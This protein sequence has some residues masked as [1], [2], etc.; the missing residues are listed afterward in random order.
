M[1]ALLLIT[2]N[3]IMAE[4][5]K[6]AETKKKAKAAAEAR[7]QINEKAALSAK[8]A[9]VVTP[10]GPQHFRVVNGEVYDTQKSELWDTRTYQLISR[11]NNLCIVKPITYQKT[12]SEHYRPAG[13]GLTGNQ[14]SGAYA[15]P[16]SSWQGGYVKTETGVQRIPGV[17]LAITNLVRKDI[18]TGQE[19]A[20]RTMPSGDAVVGGLKMKVRDVG[21][22]Y[23]PT[24]EVSQ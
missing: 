2:A 15:A 14:S 8:A 11:E 17:T 21:T 12:Y 9:S 16:G 13:G 18:R 3:N 10:T 6:T 19:F 24:A 22:L 7:A 1:V 5:K 4:T 23:C 20:L